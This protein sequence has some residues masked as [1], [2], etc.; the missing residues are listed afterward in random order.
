MIGGG[1]SSPAIIAA[2]QVEAAG[3]PSWRGV[4]R[5]VRP[6]VGPAA[7]PGSWVCVMDAASQRVA[8]SVNQT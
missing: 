7:A 8:E 3:R 2:Q 5:R 4:D 1:G 6:A